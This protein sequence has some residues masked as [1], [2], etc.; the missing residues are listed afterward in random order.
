GFLGQ[1]GRDLECVLPR[2]ADQ[3]KEPG[4]DRRHL[5]ALHRHSGPRDPLEDDAHRRMLNA[6]VYDPVV[7]AA[8]ARIA[9]DLAKLG[10]PV[11]RR[12]ERRWVLQVPCA[13]RGTLGTLVECRERTLSL[14]AFYLRAPDREREAVYRR[15]LR[16]QLDTGPWRFAL[17][18]AGDL[19]V[20]AE[21]PLAGLAADDL[22]GL[23]RPPST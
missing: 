6:P 17:D 11:E 18:D 16:R 3:R 20:V 9:G 19:Y 5:G 12:G 7:K 4:P 13:A 2:H 23:L 14:Q 8:A 21:V 15:L 22:D 1:A 10:L